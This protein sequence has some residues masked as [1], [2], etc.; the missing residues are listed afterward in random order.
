MPLVQPPYP[1]QRPHHDSVPVPI[2]PQPYLHPGVQHVPQD[3]VEWLRSGAPGPAPTGGSGPVA[4]PL[5]HMPPRQLRELPKRDLR[6]SIILGVAITMIVLG[7]VIA[8]LI[9]A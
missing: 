9:S 3:T 4:T 5:P 2:V 8:A 1:Q 7:I 6:M